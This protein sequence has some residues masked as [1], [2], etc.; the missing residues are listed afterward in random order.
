[1][2]ASDFSRRAAERPE[3]NCFRMKFLVVL[4]IIVAA[5]WWGLKGADF[6]KAK[7]AST[8]EAV[9]QS[10]SENPKKTAMTVT[11]SK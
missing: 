4:L 3:K 11:Q 5:L 10:L 6:L 1:V 7:P 8:E 9:M 2:H